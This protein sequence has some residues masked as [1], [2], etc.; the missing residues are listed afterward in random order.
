MLLEIVPTLDIGC[1]IV[2]SLVRSILRIPHVHVAA[3]FPSMTTSLDRREVLR[4]SVNAFEPVTAI[5]IIVVFADTRINT[6]ALFAQG[7][8]FRLQ[9]CIA[10]VVAAAPPQ[11][12]LIV[13]GFVPAQQPLL[14]VPLLSMHFLDVLSLSLD[15]GLTTRL[16]T[17]E[18]TLLAGIIDLGQF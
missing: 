3:I 18:V 6:V 15:Q 8:F 13:T 1:L 17:A 14:L 2:A 9:V 4:P 11:V 5:R 10:S 7:R 12:L 16:N